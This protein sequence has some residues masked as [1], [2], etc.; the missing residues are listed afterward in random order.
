VY[1]TKIYKLPTKLINPNTPT[2]TPLAYFQNPNH[3]ES[4]LSIQPQHHSQPVSP[5]N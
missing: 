2:P 5:T 4:E 3:I 1:F